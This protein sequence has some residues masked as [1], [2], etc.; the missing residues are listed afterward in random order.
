L[1]SEIEALIPFHREHL[2]E[3]KRFEGLSDPFAKKLAVFHDNSARN[4]EDMLDELQNEVNR[5][6]KLKNQHCD[7]LKQ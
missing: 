5:I 6:T 4:L 3:L 1:E 2:R 7:M